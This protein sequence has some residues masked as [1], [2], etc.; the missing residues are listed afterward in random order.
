MIRMKFISISIYD[1]LSKL[2]LINSR[3]A[4]G[5]DQKERYHG[6]EHGENTPQ[7]SNHILTLTTSNAQKKKNLFVYGLPKIPD[8]QL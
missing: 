5:N 6:R 3:F 1:V 7:T 8:I 4:P 2:Y